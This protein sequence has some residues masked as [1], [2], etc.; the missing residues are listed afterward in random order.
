MARSSPM[1]CTNATQQTV[2]GD[3][4]RLADTFVLRLFGLL[5]RTGLESGEGLLITPCNSVH[6]IGMRF[7]FD[8]IFLDA[9]NRV[10]HAMDRMKPMRLSPVVWKAKAVLECPAGTIESAQIK[11]GDQLTF[12]TTAAS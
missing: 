9:D 11:V 2:L 1:R 12:E 8:A 4:I 6:S 5:P 10:V 7:E 3:R